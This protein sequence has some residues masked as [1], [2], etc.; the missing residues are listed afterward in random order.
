VS[1]LGTTG[2]VGLLTGA[3]A[4][5]GI[6][7]QW[8]R[9]HDRWIRQVRLDAYVELVSAVHALSG[10]RLARKLIIDAVWKELEVASGVVRPARR[11]ITELIE[12]L[13]EVETVVNRLADQQ[14]DGLD[15]IDVAVA[16]VKL[17]GPPPVARF[18]QELRS[19]AG[20]I[21]RQP[22]L[23]AYGR[24][25]TALNDFV[26]EARKHVDLKRRGE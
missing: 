20:E 6:W 7:M 13:D 8:K 15:E 26:V 5:G 18:A 25:M 14:L 24:V 22:G 2:L 10:N 21:T 1:A 23:E 17:A 3:F 9:D 19:C 16:K 11:P 12:D 4:I